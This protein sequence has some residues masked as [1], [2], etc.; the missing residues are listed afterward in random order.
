VY[1]HES[2][3]L[4]S[5]LL[6]RQENVALK[7]NATQSSTYFFEDYGGFYVASRAIDGGSVAL[8]QRRM[9]TSIT[10]V[11]NSVSGVWWNLELDQD[12]II[13]Q[14]IIFNRSD[15]ITSR[16]R[17]FVLKVLDEDGNEVFTHTE[18]GTYTDADTPLSF[19]IDVNPSSNVGKQVRIELPSGK[20]L[21]L[22]EVM[23]FGVP[24]VPPVVVPDGQVGGGTYHAMKKRNCSIVIY[25]TEIKTN[26]IFLLRRPSHSA[27]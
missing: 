7:G 5:S 2:F 8:D 10:Y 24:V 1:Y 27:I 20:Q 17:G 12:Y 26:S 4:D 13:S 15:G 6:S 11:G 9:S 23:V 19:V 25:I 18:N 16:I 3:S 14:V 21:E 22:Q